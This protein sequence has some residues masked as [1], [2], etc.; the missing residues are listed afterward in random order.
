MVTAQLVGLVVVGSVLAWVLFRVVLGAVSRAIALPLALGFGASLALMQVHPAAAIVVAF[1]VYLAVGKL[2]RFS[3]R[4][5]LGFVVLVG[6]AFALHKTG[7]IGL[8]VG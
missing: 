7:L 8:P 5:L 4:L 1:L 3:G 6:V 2:V